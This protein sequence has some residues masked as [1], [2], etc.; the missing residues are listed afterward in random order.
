MTAFRIGE[1]ILGLVACALAGVIAWGTWTAPA[2]AARSVVGPGAFP[3]LVALGLLGVGLRLLYD[4]WANTSPA[5]PIPAIDWPAVLT[6]AGTLLLF[7][8]L[9]ERLGWIVAA[10]LLF[11]GVARGFGG[12]AWVANA[13]IGLVLAA[14]V[15]LVFDTLLGLSLPLGRWIEPL[16]VALGLIA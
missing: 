9:L 10:T 2:I 5:V 3:A 4:T 7:V 15:F 12:R 8:L 6:V 13:L 14:L 11:M 1:L 16:L